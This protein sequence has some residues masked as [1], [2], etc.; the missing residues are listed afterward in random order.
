ML[1]H[2]SAVYVYSACVAAC[3]IVLGASVDES[4]VL[5]INMFRFLRVLWLTHLGFRVCVQLSRNLVCKT[6]CATRLRVLSASGG[7]QKV[8][9]RTQ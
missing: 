9:A 5:S 3:G 2:G 8:V 7:L 6:C 1:A 4:L